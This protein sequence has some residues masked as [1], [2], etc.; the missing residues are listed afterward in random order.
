ML[1]L[2]VVSITVVLASSRSEMSPWRSFKLT[3]RHSGRVLLPCTFVKYNCGDYSAYLPDVVAISACI[4]VKRWPIW[5]DVRPERSSALRTAVVVQSARDTSLRARRNGDGGTG[6]R[7][8]E[9]FGRRHCKISLTVPVRK[10]PRP[11][12]RFVVLPSRI[13]TRSTRGPGVAC[14]KRCI[15]G[16][17]MEVIH[18]A[19]LT[20]RQL[21]AG[22]ARHPRQLVCTK[23]QHCIAGELGQAIL[24]GIPN[25]QPPRRLLAP[26]TEASDAPHS[27]SNVIR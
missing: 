4:N 1:I 3:I 26:D 8:E 27:P 23:G 25:L 20:C 5:S 11:T 6:G 12:S 7:N 15:T 22:R 17:A 2:C 19:R 14:G 21:H 10:T 18:L 24:L 13:A 9:H 16:Y